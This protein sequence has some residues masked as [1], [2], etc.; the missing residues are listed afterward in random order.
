MFGNVVPHQN[1][2]DAKW[3]DRFTR[4]MSYSILNAHTTGIV[5]EIELKNLHILN[6]KNSNRLPHT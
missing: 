4:T 6:T 2:V 1:A 3:D 5:F